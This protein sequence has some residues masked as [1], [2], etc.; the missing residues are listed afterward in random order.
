MPRPVGTG[1]LAVHLR[2]CKHF[3]QFALARVQ[4][5]RE[6]L[7]A[8]LALCKLVSKTLEVGLVLGCR[9][10]VVEAAGVPLLAV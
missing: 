10:P 8:F 4:L 5:G 1:A 9:L 2:H 7:L 3:A 6:S